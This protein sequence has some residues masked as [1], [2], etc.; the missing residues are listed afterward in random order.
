MEGGMESW[1]RRRR[2]RR[3]ETEAVLS[4]RVLWRGNLAS[5]FGK[6][7]PVRLV[8]WDSAVANQL[9]KSLP[10]IPVAPALLWLFI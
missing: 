5:H 7:K 4:R 8:C 6:E 1:R 9:A 2:R 10:C 3:V